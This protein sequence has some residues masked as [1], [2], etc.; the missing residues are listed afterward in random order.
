[1]S[2][3]EFGLMHGSH[4]DELVTHPQFPVHSLRV[5]EPQLCDPTVQQYSG[6]LDID[7][8]KHLFYWFFES[9]VDPDNAPLVLWLNGA[10][11]A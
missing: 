10:W 11:I 5:K 4:I 9:R 6:Y 8:D 1:M 2:P 3:N 7:D